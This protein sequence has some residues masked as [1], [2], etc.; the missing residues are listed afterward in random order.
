MGYGVGVD[1]ELVGGWGKK[2]QLGIDGV[3]VVV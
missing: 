1:Y 2:F 3:V